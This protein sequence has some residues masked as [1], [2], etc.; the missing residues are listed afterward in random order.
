MSAATFAQFVVAGLKYGAIYALMAL[1]FTIVYGATGVINFAQGEFYMLGGML[2]V[3]AFSALGLPLPLALLLAVAAAAAAGAL[4]ELVAI[5]P[6]KD[7]DPL[8]LI[9]ITIGGSMLISSLA[10]HVWGA[11]ELALRRAGGVDLNAFTPGDSILLLGA[12]I[13]RQALWIWGLTV[14]AVIALTLLY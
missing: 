3:W 6:R 1:G 5:R 4:F 8:A 12:A 13:E 7:G 2:L 11:N 9:I 14:L 10:R